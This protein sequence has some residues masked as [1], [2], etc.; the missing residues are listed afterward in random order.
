M[1]Q[2]E[3]GRTVMV[4]WHRGAWDD[5]MPR[6]PS[7]Y[8]CTSSVQPVELVVECAAALMAARSLRKFYVSIARSFLN[9][10][11]FCSAV[12]LVRDVVNNTA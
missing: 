11:F 1:Y 2:G 4:L 5:T 3:F 10:T 7:L 9:E 12:G 6:I 8:S